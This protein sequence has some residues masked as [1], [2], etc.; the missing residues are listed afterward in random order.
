MEGGRGGH[1]G[2]QACAVVGPSKGRKAAA[3]LTR[4]PA[5]VK[6]LQ[7]PLS[8]RRPTRG[9]ARRGRAA[10][11][12]APRGAAVRSTAPCKRRAGPHGRQR[13]SGGGKGPT[14][15]HLVLVL[16][17]HCRDCTRH[18]QPGDQRPHVEA[19]GA[20][21]L[22]HLSP[23]GGAF[24]GNDGR[25]RG[26]DRG[27][28]GLRACPPVLLLLHAHLCA[29]PRGRNRARRSWRA[30]LA[31]PWGRR[32]FFMRNFFRRNCGRDLATGGKRRPTILRPKNGGRGPRGPRPRGR[33]RVGGR[34]A[35][36][37]SPR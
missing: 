27:L 29:C 37:L 33:P 35:A 5:A 32:Q 6:R 24:C 28:R 26:G 22:R 25:G 14:R 1:C 30:P 17:R 34:R 12:A 4:C 8:L 7:Q 19:G 23:G 31:C 21:A 13:E 2:R 9:E 10:A 15:R 16:G 11:V 18:H 3:S 36:L 20:A